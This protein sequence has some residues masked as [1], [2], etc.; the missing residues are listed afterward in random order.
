M[1]PIYVCLI[2]MLIVVGAILLLRVHAFLALLL[3]A[4]VVMCL[5]TTTPSEFFGGQNSPGLATVPKSMVD[6]FGSGC[7]KV[8]IIIALAAIIGQC[9]LESRA[10]VFFWGFRSSSTR[11]STCCFQSSASI[12]V[13][14]KEPICFVCL[15]Q[16]RAQVWPI[17][18]FPRPL[19]H[20]S[21]R[22]S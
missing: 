1:A 15:R 3:G 21:S 5:T 6:G 14:R 12:L 11:S 20:C 18:S 19:G 8:G 16:L 22:Q 2:G 13:G 7:A 4:L 17:R 10:A 9:L